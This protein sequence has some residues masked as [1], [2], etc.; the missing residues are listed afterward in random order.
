DNRK[1]ATGRQEIEPHLG[2]SSED[3]RARIVETAGAEDFQINRSKRAFRR[4]QQPQFV[5]QLSKSDTAPPN[6][7]ISRTRHDDERVVVK[8]FEAKYL[9]RK[10]AQSAC[11][12]DIDLTL[13][14]F[15]VQCVRFRNEMKR[16]SRI[17]LG[18]PLDDGRNEGAGEKGAASDPHFPSR[19]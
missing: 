19:R 6:P 13:A 15:T 3:S 17:T 4:W 10:E 14:Q 16:D 7:P 11:D 5:H 2:G 8:V 18:E 1:K 9:I 12:Q